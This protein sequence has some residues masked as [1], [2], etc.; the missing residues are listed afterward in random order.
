MSG[1]APVPRRLL[2]AAFAGVRSFAAGAAAPAS[3]RVP[4]SAPSP[5]ARR[6]L[7]D[8]GGEFVGDAIADRV[9]AV[10]S[11]A[12][13][14]RLGFGTGRPRLGDG[15]AANP[16]DRE[17]LPVRRPVG[18][19]FPAIA[20]APMTRGGGAD[21]R[22]LRAASV[23]GTGFR[24]GGEYCF[25]RSHPAADPLDQMAPVHFRRAAGRLALLGEGLADRP[26][27]RPR[28]ALAAP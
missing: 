26:G 10:E 28:R 1:P 16:D 2:P 7:V 13:A 12:G 6:D 18:S 25:D 19:L 17:A 11:D 8:A 14:E 23:P 22:P 5:E 15:A 27:R 20:A 21:L 24:T 3:A 4:D 9:A